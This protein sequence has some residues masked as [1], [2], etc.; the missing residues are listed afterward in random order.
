MSLHHSYLA[1][2]AAAGRARRNAARTQASQS[3]TLFGY[4]AAGVGPGGR[5]TGPSLGGA[6]A[7]AQTRAVAAMPLIGMGGLGA[8]PAAAGATA[9]NATAAPFGNRYGRPPSHGSNPF[10]RGIT[11]FADGAGGGYADP[12]ARFEGAVGQAGN[13]FLAI[14]KGASPTAPYD[15]VLRHSAREAA[16]AKAEIGATQA[17]FDAY[18]PAPRHDARAAAARLGVPLG[19]GDAPNMASYML[20]MQNAY[21][22]G[23]ANSGGSSVPPSITRLRQGNT[24]TF[25][26]L[27]NLAQW[28]KALGFDPAGPGKWNVGLRS[29]ESAAWAIWYAQ[30]AKRNAAGNYPGMSNWDSARDAFR[31]AYWNLRMARTLGPETAQRF[32]D[33]Q[34][35]GSTN[36]AGSRLMDLWNNFVGRRLAAD[37]ALANR[38]P[39]DVVRDAI[40]RRALQTPPFTVRNGIPSP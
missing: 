6:V 1:G 36:T 28:Y 38:L 3:P 20:A 30:L 32:A 17:L 33:S 34:E 31:H 9:A 21:G 39:A 11:G 12:G 35:I 29:P 40:S 18:M 27:L 22:S 4:N 37:P 16:A 19:A 5:T 13:A 15:Q 26:P 24:G 23:A 25:N 7:Q 10:L 2:L 8:S 14:L